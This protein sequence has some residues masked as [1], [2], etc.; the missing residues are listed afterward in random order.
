MRLILLSGIL[1][2]ALSFSD[3]T[4]QYTSGPGTGNSRGLPGTSCQRKGVAVALGLSPLKVMH[5]GK[6]KQLVPLVINYSD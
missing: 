4:V 2:R 6:Q 5:L 1:K 3:W